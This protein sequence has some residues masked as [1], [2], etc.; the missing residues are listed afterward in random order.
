MPSFVSSFTLH[1]SYPRPYA[2]NS[3]FSAFH[4]LHHDDERR[5][6]FVDRQ[7]HVILR[8]DISYLPF[9]IR[10]QPKANIDSLLSRPIFVKALIIMTYVSLCQMTISVELA[11][12]DISI[13][14][15]PWVIFFSLI[16]TVSSSL[17]RQKSSDSM[18]NSISTIPRF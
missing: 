10:K 3:S 13:E 4:G 1:S 14:N 11:W 6:Y 5:N 12:D 8:N 16:F 17:E 18:G 9:L 2:K 15:C 7:L